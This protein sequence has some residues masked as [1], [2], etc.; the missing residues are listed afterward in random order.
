MIPPCAPRSISILTCCRRRRRPAAARGSTAG[1]VLSELARKGLESLKAGRVRNGVPL[2]PRRLAGART[3]MTLVNDLR[4]EPVSARGAGWTSQSRGAGFVRAA[5][6]PCYRVNS[7]RSD[8]LAVI[9][10]DAG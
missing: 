8:Q 5:T 7:I 2:L 9:G 4:D 10:P 1:K 3:T 6:N